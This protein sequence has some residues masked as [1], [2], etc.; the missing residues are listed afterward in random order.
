[1]W[2]PHQ[3]DQ[4]V[5]ASSDLRL[6]EIEAKASLE[7]GTSKRRSQINLVSVNSEVQGCKCVAW[8]PDPSTPSMLAAGLPSGKVVLTSFRESSSSFSSMANSIVKEFMPRN[9]R[10]CNALAWNPVHHNEIAAGLGKVRCDFSTLVWDLNQTSGTPPPQKKER[11]RET[12]NK[13][14][15]KT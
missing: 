3:A 4:F 7:P 9:S 5:I 15:H 2:S 8:S 1:M 13:Q 12:G 14:S 6:Y 11:E 10:S